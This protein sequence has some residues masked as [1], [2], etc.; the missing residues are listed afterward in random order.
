LTAKAALFYLDT[1]IVNNSFNLGRIIPSIKV[2]LE[3]FLSSSA[4]ASELKSTSS[5][6]SFSCFSSASSS[7]SLNCFLV[8]TRQEKFYFF[9]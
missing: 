7:S 8:G 1:I 2:F 4:N 3:T 5:L 9:R 6:E